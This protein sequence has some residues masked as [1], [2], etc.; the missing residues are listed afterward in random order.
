MG[1]IASR[2]GTEPMEMADDVV[3]LLLRGKAAIYSCATKTPCYAVDSRGVFFGVDRMSERCGLCQILAK[4][5]DSPV[6]SCDEVLRH[7]ILQAERFGGAYMSLCPNNLLITTAIVRK[8]AET[9]G[10]L[11][12]GPALL[13]NREEFMAEEFAANKNR[14][15]PELKGL[16]SILDSIS[17]VDTVR[18]KALADMLDIAA[19]DA[20]AELE[21][22]LESNADASQRNARIAEY[23]QNL[24]VQE[25]D[26]ARD[27]E[28]LA[29]YPFEKERV[30]IHL[31]T[32]GNRAGARKIL[33]EILGAVFF[34]GGGEIHGA[35][36]RALELAVLLSRA[37]VEGG[38]TAQEIFGASEDFIKGISSCHTID[39]LASRLAVAVNRFTDFVFPLT[40]KKNA[41]M[42]LKAERFIKEHY[43]EDI[44]L[45]D[46]AR[47]VNLSPSYFSSVFKNGTGSGFSVFLNAVRISKSK[48]LLKACDIAISEV[49]GLVGFIDQSYFCKIFKKMV[50][51]P[52]G[53]FRKGNFFPESNIEIHNGTK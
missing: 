2:S 29:G 12:A 40:R 10:A 22:R 16:E 21:G 23:V 20:G 26:R 25:F 41:D 47:E 46:V 39:D 9:M 19:R 53:V 48:E 33:N 35:R 3:A 18:A 17:N 44:T 24:K 49:S 5:P 34:S 50:G 8:E 11:I 13:V 31:V 6:P 52:P 51:V 14:V 45:E 43:R 27:E 37:A 42:I 36:A 4:S 15:S 28:I 32:T 30:L 7:G 1:C 38:A